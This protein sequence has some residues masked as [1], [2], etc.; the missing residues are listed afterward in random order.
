[1]IALELSG[2]HIGRKMRISY[3][4]RRKNAVLH[5]IDNFTPS[6][7]SHYRHSERIYMED[8]YYNDI[9]IPFW[10]EVEFLD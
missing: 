4:F 6:K 7:L 2:V 1:M 8:G 5:V 10:A 9:V 3:K